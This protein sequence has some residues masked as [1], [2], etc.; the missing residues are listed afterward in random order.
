MTISRK[1]KISFS[2]LI[3]S[4]ITIFSYNLILNIKNA[5]LIHT[6]NSYNIKKLLIFKDLQFNTVQIQQFLTDI[7][8]TRALP[9]FDDGYKEAEI[10]FKNALNDLDSLKKLENNSNLDYIDKINSDLNSY[11]ETGKKMAN[12]Y[13]QQ[14]PEKGNEYM[15]LF[16]PLA[17]GLTT[18]I[19][20]YVKENQAI[21]DK[22]LNLS[23]NDMDI[24]TQTQS[25]SLIFIVVLSFFILI[26]LLKSVIP[27]IKRMNSIIYDLLKG[28][29]DLTLR[30]DSRGNDEISEISN[31]L[32]HFLDFLA[33]LI[34]NTKNESD[35]VLNNSIEIIS[36]TKKVKALAHEQNTMK[37]HL[38]NNMIT[39]KEKMN[40]VLSSVRN[41]AAGSEEIASAIYEI[42][43]TITN[44][45]NYT[46]VTSV[47]Y[48]ET[49]IS[50]EDGYNLMNKAILEIESLFDFILKID[51]KLQGLNAISRQTNLLALNAAI[52]TSSAGEAGKGFM[53]VSEEIKKLSIVSTEFTNTIYELNN[54][55]KKHA[56]SSTEISK[57]VM[58][59]IKEVKEKV[60]ISKNEISTVKT[61][62]SEQKNVISEIEKNSQSF[63]NESLSIEENTM[64]QL[65]NLNDFEN[66]LHNLANTVE[67]NNKSSDLSWKYASALDNT[68]KQLK[69]QISNFK[70]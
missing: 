10:S 67:E 16:D 63:A 50:T 57:S 38:E 52:E 7:S 29:G 30:M 20:T 66:V 32:N 56:K 21:V 6:T 27:S 4:I 24:S 53:I 60:E 41:Q 42:S 40:F 12:I 17:E 31:N 47:H 49:Y 55:I 69:E 39:L 28:S 62:I 59:K 54:E 15:K 43:S 37:N 11:Y 5:R 3:L 44:I 2:F 51:E 26:V 45:S 70:I 23:I 35:N 58:S 33:L 1:I 14:G 65:N 22:N 64:E 68:A 13:I 19:E 18:E 36:Q 48:E 61:A 9:G 34:K 25:I 8:A 46:N